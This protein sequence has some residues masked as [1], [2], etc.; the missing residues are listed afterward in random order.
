MQEQEGR[1]NHRKSI[2]ITIN[3]HWSLGSLPVAGWAITAAQR[4]GFLAPSVL[5]LS[6]QQTQL[7]ASTS[8]VLRACAV[9]R[10]NLLKGKAEDQV[11]ET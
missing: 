4:P 5:S 3:K 9:V 2:C 11:F 7:C 1:E 10:D 8:P 6:H